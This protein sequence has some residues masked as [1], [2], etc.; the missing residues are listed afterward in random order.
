MDAKEKIA[1]IKRN[2]LEI[3]EEAELKKL[4]EE[5]PRPI[6]Y[7]GYEPSGEIHLGHMVTVA[8][9]M[10]LEKAGF[11]VKVLL[12]DWH[13]WL[14]KKGDWNFI[15]EQAE[16]WKKAFRQLGLESPEFVLGSDF[17]RT[18]E[19]INDLMALSLNTTVKRGL[20][21]MQEIAR[22][23]EHA[24]ISQ[25]IY[26]LMQ[27]IDI[28]HLHVDVA[29]AGIEQ[30][31]IHML[32][33]EELDK[34]GYKKPILVHTPLIESLLGPG[35][36]MASSVPGSI[37]SVRDSEKDVEKKIANA[38]CK[39]GE[40]KGNPILQIAQLV[41]LPRI[42]QLKVERQK[43]FGGD[44]S[45]KSYSELEKAFEKKQLHPADLK[46]AVSSEL[47]ELLEPVRKVFE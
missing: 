29:Q 34:I 30:R 16:L 46:K 43:K 15:N 40:A 1:L 17:Q 7:C 24:T 13:A 4:L 21:S 36:K 19:Y 8:K 3:I 14:N 33:R 27:V 42:G 26:P 10:D 31:K 35:K 38:Y 23:V 5:K 39:E 6:T 18:Y 32:A 20:R 41:V 25:I 2:T 37:L 44:I 9:L 47:I 11:K 45:F 28:K 22:N 12:A